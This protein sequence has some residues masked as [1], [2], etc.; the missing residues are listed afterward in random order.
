[1]VKP[2]LASNLKRRAGFTLIELLVVLAIIATL[3]T[4][5]LPRY[6]NSLD[7]SKETVLLENLRVTRDAIDRFYGDKGRYP[8]TLDE[9]VSSRYLRSRPVDPIA[10]SDASW[11]ILPPPGDLKG[12]VYDIKSSAAGQSRDGRAFGEL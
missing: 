8:E 9:L 11:K 2:V 6:F 5:A 12:K 4:I 7:S 10:E 3:L 1:M